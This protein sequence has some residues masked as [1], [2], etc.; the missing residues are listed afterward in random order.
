MGGGGM[1]GRGVG[2]GRVWWREAG[3]CGGWSLEEGCIFFGMHFSQS[4]NACLLNFLLDCGKNEN[5]E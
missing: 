1:C 2:W 4:K 3:I 5:K